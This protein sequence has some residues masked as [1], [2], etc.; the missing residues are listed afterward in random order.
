[1]RLCHGLFL[2][3]LGGEVG[4][5]AKSGACECAVIFGGASTCRGTRCEHSVLVGESRYLAPS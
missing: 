3:P 4:A 5:S 2:C 1:M